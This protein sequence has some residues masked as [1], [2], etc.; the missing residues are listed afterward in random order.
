MFAG[1][2]VYGEREQTACEPGVAT[3]GVQ[4]RTAEC[5]CKDRLKVLQVGEPIPG[6]D[7]GSV[8]RRGGTLRIHLDA[9]LPSLNRLIDSDD[10]IKRIVHHDVYQALVRQNPHDYSFEPELATRWEHNAL[11]TEWTFHL[12]DGVRWH[13]GKPFTA[14]DVKFTFDAIMNPNN[15]TEAPRSDWQ[16]LIDPRAPFEA[17]DDHTFI[18]RL[19]QPSA[20]FLTNLEDIT[21]VPEHIFARGD[22]NTHP[23]L[24]KPVG[25][26]PF[27]FKEW[28]ADAIVLERNP[29]YWGRPAYLDSIV[30][31]T[32]IDRETGF[33]MTLRGDIDFN[34]RLMPHQRLEGLPPEALER[35]RVVDYLPANQYGFWIYNTTKPQFA[36]V[37]T[38]R[39]MSM[40]ID[41]NQIICEIYQCLAAPSDSPVPRNHPA[42]NSSLK[43]FAFDPEGAKKL[44]SEAGWEDRDGDGVREKVI[45]GKTVPFTINFLLTQ[46]SR[47]LEQSVTVVQNAMRRAG[48]D[49]QITKLDW[50]V[51]IERMRKHD[52]EVGSFIFTVPHEADLYI[53]F[54]SEGGQN[55]GQWKNKELDALA[56]ESRFIMNP[57][58]RNLALRRS[59]EIIFEEQPYTFTYT[60]VLS[61][62]MRKDLRGVYTSDHWYQEYDMWI[63]DPK[64]PEVPP[65]ER[66]PGHPGAPPLDEAGR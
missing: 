29:D 21:I 42:Y 30:Y 33:A 18:I 16:D 14:R 45:D 39:A 3:S 43:G 2:P 12:R 61:G 35:L 31:R 5:G 22:L 19:R 55:F 49:L 66:H 62:L 47:A 53:G 40:L 7:D 28:T 11:G 64:L 4:T 36:D 20:L 6:M 63:D 32:V 51:Y 50:S 9:N 8:P 27:K 41:R 44:L 52:F 60:Q 57:T 48:V 25:T 17:P 15:R 54:H 26:G 34:P 65:A 13:D 24:R 59:Q 56:D 23:N 37:R 38:R 58:L 10:W 1:C 46:G